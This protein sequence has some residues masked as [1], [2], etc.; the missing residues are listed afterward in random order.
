MIFQ[1]TAVDTQATAI[2]A[3]GRQYAY[4]DLDRQSAQM[5]AILLLQARENIPGQIAFM[6]D[7]G[8]DY[9]A[10]LWGIWKAGGMAVPLC[11]SYPLPSLQY[12]LEDAAVSQ[13][14]VSPTYAKLLEAHCA[15][16]G[17]TMHV[18]GQSL[19]PSPLELP[20]LSEDSPALMLY[21]SGTTNL[22]KG[23]VLTHA[24]LKAQ[25]EILVG[26]W[27]WTSEDHILCVLPLH[28]VHGV[29]NVVGCALYVGAKLTFLPQFSPEAV[30]RIFREDGLSLF[31]AVPT[32]YYKLIA[33]WESLPESGQSA[34]TAAM[35]NFRLMVCGS[36]A[37]PVTTME[38]W[39]TISGHTLLE[40]YGMTEIGMAISNPYTGERRAGYIGQ[41]L[42]GV[43]VRLVDEALQPVLAGEMGEIHVRG[44]NVFSRYWRRPDQTKEA[45]TPDG[46]FKTGDMAVVEEGYYRIT[47]RN[48][49]DIIKSGG[50]KLSA[51]EIEEVLRTYPGIADVA[52]VGIPDEEWGE[53]VVAAL[54]IT[55]TIDLEQ[56]NA[57]IRGQMAAY[58][59]PKKYLVVDE[60][61]RNA[62][63]K[64]VKNEVKQFF[65]P[66]QVL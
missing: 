60:L 10:V 65:K 22:P 40:R 30:F 46:W 1:H 33:Y 42:S 15:D 17:I 64:V 19:D 44:R 61:P 5:A 34:L 11:L 20:E 31:M 13:V 50:Y 49:V 62:M 29:V 7:P 37:L 9:V 35:K 58:K 36:A 47:G 28:H 32:I 4:G 57:W 48:S 27:Q 52:V 38:K 14:V 6:V 12:V 23:V 21:T 8:F 53:K 3:E 54:T 63:G 2:V 39:K 43:E 45:F 18:L 55:Q 51:L 25:V 26:A 66:N 24:N 41:P 56:L 59:T 16:A